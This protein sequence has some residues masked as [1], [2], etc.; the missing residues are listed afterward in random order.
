MAA[1]EKGISYICK[2]KK[3]TQEGELV[4]RSV[5]GEV[6]TP[7]VNRV[8]RDGNVYEIQCPGCGSVSRVARTP[9][10]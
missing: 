2:G 5:C 6:L 4:G 1:T 9:E 3:V 8:P 10:K 7:K